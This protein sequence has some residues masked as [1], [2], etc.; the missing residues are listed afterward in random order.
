[1]TQITCTSID[2]LY[3]ADTRLCHNAIPMGVQH[4]M[5]ETRFMD[6]GL[7]SVGVR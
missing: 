5:L 2:S 6:T 7:F 4:C 1:V 3:N